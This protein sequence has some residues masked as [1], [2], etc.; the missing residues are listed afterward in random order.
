MARPDDGNSLGFMGGVL[1]RSKKVLFP[2]EV[3]SPEAD[4]SSGGGGGG[5]AGAGFAVASSSSTSTW[6]GRSKTRAR[7][8]RLAAS[9]SSLADFAAAPI[10]AERGGPAGAVGGGVA[11][12]ENRKPTTEKS[13]AKREGSSPT[14]ES[15]AA[16]LADVSMTRRDDGRSDAAGAGRRK[17]RS[18]E[19]GVDG[20]HRRG[21]R[22]GTRAEDSS[23]YF[24]GEPPPP[25]GGGNPEKNIR[26]RM[27]N[28]AKR[29]SKE[30][31]ESNFS[32]DE[33]TYSIA[34]I[35]N[36]LVG[37][38][39]N[40]RKNRG[41]GRRNHPVSSLVQTE[42][43]EERCKRNSGLSSLMT[44]TSSIQQT[45]KS[46]RSKRDKWKANHRAIPSH[47]SGQA[48]IPSDDRG[49]V[50]SLTNIVE[51]LTIGDLAVCSTPLTIRHRALP[52]GITSPPVFLHRFS[53]L[54]NAN[55]FDRSPMLDSNPNLKKR[56]DGKK[57]PSSKKM[58]IKPPATSP[59]PLSMVTKM[60]TSPYVFENA[61]EEKACAQINKARDNTGSPCVLVLSSSYISSPNNECNALSHA[62]SNLFSS[63]GDTLEAEVLRPGSVVTLE[64][65]TPRHKKHDF[66]V[67][68]T[69]S[70][71]PKGPV[72]GSAV[73]DVEVVVPVIRKESDAFV[74]PR[75]KFQTKEAANEDKSTNTAVNKKVSVRPR[76]ATKVVEDDQVTEVRR[77]S[78]QSKPTDRLTVTSW[79]NEDNKNSDEKVRFD[80]SVD[81]YGSG[82][83]VIEEAVNHT[84][85]MEKQSSAVEQADATKEV[86]ISDDASTLNSERTASNYNTLQARKSTADGS[87]TDQE[88]SYA[89]LRILRHCQKEI[90][91]TS[92]LYW[93]EVA[94]RVGTK[95]SSEC[96]V[97]WQSLV[98]T[99]K[100]RKAP[101][102]ARN[103]HHHSKGGVVDASIL[104]DDEDEDDLFNSSPYRESNLEDGKETNA[105]MFTSFGTSRG[106]TPCIKQ[107]TI[108]NEPSALK[109]RR[110]GYNTYIGKT[111]KMTCLVC[112]SPYLVIGRYA[113][114]P[115]LIF[116]SSVAHY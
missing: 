53:T 84:L 46:R 1:G 49:N 116:A 24:C 111:R 57:T 106:L 107:I 97:K 47:S 22:N 83:E 99:P 73:F 77:S 54:A 3:E 96:Q 13:L 110:K 68:T 88:W 71:T 72:R 92:T 70:A 26:R 30:R 60:S 61:G 100:D 81:A 98:P 82:C 94:N 102:S 23:L 67:R 85:S 6:G 40:M 21:S 27:K 9:N 19:G 32:A 10:A 78:R 65:A 18:M 45:Q 74:A 109:F 101:K 38:K 115:A 62:R 80:N 29:E 20:L 55:I 104:D 66:I 36:S 34:E 87:A 64:V 25:V 44:L 113:L 103:L 63:N 51:S 39:T 4:A 93:Q 105:R 89:D 52:G 91:P 7:R 75:R 48:S 112:M 33:T 95:T 76:V 114:A 42:E 15:L 2:E 17:G 59:S 43:T 35:D 16:S 8:A 108:S 5:V 90:N 79:V 12:K 28:Y 41:R 69:T 56:F 14:M 11:G 31:V 58:P 37:G 86:K 50:A